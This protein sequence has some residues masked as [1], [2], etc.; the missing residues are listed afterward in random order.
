M[1]MADQQQPD[2]AGEEDDGEESELT[3]GE[4]MTRMKLM[5]SKCESAPY[6]LMQDCFDEPLCDE[7]EHVFEKAYSTNMLDNLE[8]KE[9]SDMDEELAM[10]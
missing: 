3:E 5:N 2:F 8:L 4:I 10:Q 6:L 7:E 9:A 1:M